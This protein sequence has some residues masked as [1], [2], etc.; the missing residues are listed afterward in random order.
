[1]R[2]SSALE[3]DDGTAATPTTT[4]AAAA[5][6]S[7][8][9][10]P[11]IHSAAST[12]SA[13]G[14]FR[15][16]VGASSSSTPLLGVKKS[17]HY[18][19]QYN[20]LPSLSSSP[21]KKSQQLNHLNHQ[22]A[23]Q[24]A[25][26]HPA[27]RPM[28]VPGRATRRK[29]GSPNADGSRSRDGSGSGSRRRSLKG[30]VRKFCNRFYAKWFRSLFR[31]FSS[32]SFAVLLWYSLGVISIGTSKYL[33][34]KHHHHRHHRDQG[35][36]NSNQNSGFELI[37]QVP[38]LFLTLQ[39]FLIGSTLL[40][41]LLHVGF[42]GSPGLQPWPIANHHHSHP[43]LHGIHQYHPNGSSNGGSAST[44]SP[45]ATSKS[46]N[47]LH[48]NPSWQSI[49]AAILSEY[50][51][52]QLF[53]AAMYFSCGFLATNYGF[54]STSASFVE[55][56]KAAEP[57]TSATVAVLWGIEVL[58]HPEMGSL[59]VIVAGVLL[60][61]LGNGGEAHPATTGAVL[62]A[63]TAAAAVP[64]TSSNMS[65]SLRACLIVMASN[66]CFSF[67]GLY[68][69][70]F[71]ATR[72]TSASGANASSL[73]DLNL[74]F[75]MQ[76][77]GVIL[78]AIPVIIF[79]LPGMVQHIWN[80]WR[81]YGFIES[82]GLFWRYVAIA[83]VNGCAFTSYNLASTYILSRISVVHHAALNCIRRM[84]A[85]IVTSILF[86]VPITMLGGLGI[87]LSFIGFMAFTHYKVQRQ[88]TPKPISS[89]LPISAVNFNE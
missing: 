34:M 58:S 20:P 6:S 41:V 75:R 32:L 16:M 79:D 57:I 10:S 11:N 42:L 83:L 8:S 68:Q 28:A 54:A 64:M 43:P 39:Q 59:G 46:N 33:L 63:E 77:V 38:P 13:S 18:G 74:Q 61:T 67:R 71:Q 40:R 22:N 23:H 86:S 80:I 31:N 14:P 3:I 9:A 60:S 76:Q 70:L 37:G 85:I 21:P 1:M 62:D 84:F 2:R 36:S 25:T 87:L 48:D 50:Q 72:N 19:F 89:L 30:I 4:A 17:L 88:N 65:D 73:D 82:H 26:T 29:R 12:P 78:F 45:F 5:S 69:K 44:S 81:H 49:V 47:S 27:L 53:L 56:I 24:S 66:L 35:E 7:S 15:V 51:P 52:Q 55:T